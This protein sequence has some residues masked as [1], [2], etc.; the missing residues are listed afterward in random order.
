MTEN[1]Q[2]QRV[3]Y[4][5][6]A[7]VFVN[8]S[9]VDPGVAAPAGAE[10]IGGRVYVWAAPGLEGPALKRLP[11]DAMPEVGAA[12]PTASEQAEAAARH[13]LTEARQRID[14]LSHELAAVAKERHE[15]A[16][17]LAAADEAIA[18]LQQKSSELEKQLAAA[19]RK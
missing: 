2:R 5:V 18:A 1:V 6:M 4:E 15:F 3:R 12:P 9:Y 16:L 13:E 19:K 14:A 8:N 11:E 10:R 17:K 7:P